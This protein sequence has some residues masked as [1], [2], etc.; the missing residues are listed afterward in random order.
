ME[1]YLKFCFL[2]D[3]LSGN[4]VLPW[5]AC[6]MLSDAIILP[7]F[8]AFNSSSHFKDPMWSVSMEWTPACFV[9]RSFVSSFSSNM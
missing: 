1:G 2:W 3:T 9:S 4:S 6:V 8:H 7:A 5:S